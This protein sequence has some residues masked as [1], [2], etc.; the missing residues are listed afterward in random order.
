M[1]QARINRSGGTGAIHLEQVQ[2]R[3]HPDEP[4]VLTGFN[5]QV[6][7]GEMC[8]PT[9]AQWCRENNCPTR[10]C[11]FRASDQRICAT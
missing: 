2:T 5:L 11:R 8:L 1:I 9:W 6:Q 4:P 3:Y 7:E 10:Y